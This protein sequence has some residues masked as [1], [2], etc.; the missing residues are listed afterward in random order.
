[1]D[2]QGSGSITLLDINHNW[3]EFQNITLK[4]SYRCAD[5]NGGPDYLFFRQCIF[6]GA[7]TNPFYYGYGNNFSTWYQCIFR[8]GGTLAYGNAHSSAQLFCRFENVT[9]S[10]MAPCLFY[11]CLFKDITV[12][13]A[14][15]YPAMYFVHCVMHSNTNDGI[16]TGGIDGGA[17]HAIGCRITR[18]GGWG[19]QCDNTA[20]NTGPVS[21]NN[22][23]YNNSSGN[24]SAGVRSIGDLDATTATEE[25]YTDESTGDFNLTTDAIGRSIEN[26]IDW[27]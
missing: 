23:Y 14:D 15:S 3:L 22:V 7:G 16:R 21:I 11:G 5:G 4:D 8:N 27:E 9:F 6:E 13:D 18:N 19:L 17:L 24:R 1:M 26:I 25:G 2:G 20:T 10:N 12:L